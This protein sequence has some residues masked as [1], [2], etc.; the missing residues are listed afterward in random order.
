MNKIKTVLYAD[1]HVD[2]YKEKP[3]DAAEKLSKIWIQEKQE[4]IDVWG[5]DWPCKEFFEAFLDHCREAEVLKEALKIQWMVHNCPGS[6]TEPCHHERVCQQVIDYSK[7]Y[8]LESETIW[9]KDSGLDKFVLMD[10]LLGPCTSLFSNFYKD[11][12]KRLVYIYPNPKDSDGRF[13][14]LIKDK[15]TG[16]QIN[17]PRNE[18]GKFMTVVE[19]DEKGI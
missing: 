3:L 16:E 19:L 7:K 18:N 2:K 8:G 1:L 12:Y 11:N 4:I 10:E 15:R 17:W 6:E 5:C 13:I 14:P 9:L